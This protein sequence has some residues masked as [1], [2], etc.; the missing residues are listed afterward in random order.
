ARSRNAAYSSA[1]VVARS[2]DG[3]HQKQPRRYSAGALSIRYLPP[4]SRSVLLARRR[5]YP[6][7]RPHPVRELEGQ[8][9]VVLASRIEH[10][11]RRIEAHL[12][13][14]M[15]WSAGGRSAIVLRSRTRRSDRRRV[16]VG[17][18]LWM[19]RIADVE[20]ANAGFEVPA[21]QRGRI[22]LIVDAA[23]MAAI[24]EPG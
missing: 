11:G 9:A 21:C 2:V 6:G 12:R 14:T 1:R 18:L 5:R 19:H 10:R 7:E 8:E 23:V 3:S 22:L 20:Y 15:V 13:G 4:A 24:S 16:E 17:N